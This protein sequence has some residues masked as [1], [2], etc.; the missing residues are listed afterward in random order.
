MPLFAD[1]VHEEFSTVVAR[2][3]ALRRCRL[4][5]GTGAGRP[6]AGRRRRLVLRRVPR[7][8]R[9]A[10]STRATGPPPP[11]RS[12]PPATATSGRRHARHR[13]PPPLRHARRSPPRG[14]LP[15]ADGD[16]RQGDG[17]RA[18]AAEQLTVPYEGTTHAGVASCARRATRTRCARPS[19][20]AAVGTRRSWRTTS[21][22]ASPP[23]PA[24]TTSCCTTAPDRV[25]C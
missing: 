6:G 12:P 21:P 7:P 19:S 25:A 4:R 16:V 14:C 22:S 3:R 20:S 17:A 8:R 18:V 9:S 13:L 5:R 11:G 23:W 24:A 15:P 10:A 1:E 2:L